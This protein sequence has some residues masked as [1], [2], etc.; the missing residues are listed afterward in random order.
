MSIYCLV[1]LGSIE[2]KPPIGNAII[3]LCIPGIIGWPGIADIGGGYI[4]PSM[5]L[6]YPNKLPV[7]AWNP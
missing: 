4:A 5:P 6:G 7:P 3:E 2:G 1:I